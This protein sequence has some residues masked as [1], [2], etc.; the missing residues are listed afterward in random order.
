MSAFNRYLASVDGKNFLVTNLIAEIANSYYELLALDNQLAI[1]RQNIEIQSNALEIVKYQKQSARVTE[2]AVKRFEAQ[3]LNTKSLQFEIQQQI[4]ETENL[5]NFLIGR[6]PQPINRDSES[7]GRFTP[8]MIAEGIPSQL[9][10]NRPDIRQ[11]ELELMAARLDVKSAKANFYPSL[12]ISAGVGYQAFNPAY[13]LKTPE[14]LLY[15]LAGELTAPL[16]NRK[17]IKAIY[18][19][20]NAKQI[21][22][23]FNYEQTVLN[24]YV[25]VANELANINNLASAYDLR[26]RQV[27]VLNESV[28]ISNTLFKSARADYMEVLLTQREA[29]DSRF[30]LIETRMEQLRAVVRVYRSLGGGWK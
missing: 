19:N 18:Q 9:L 5:I 7:F 21:Q 24:A 27:D 25:E 8:N 26:A 28:D 4:I 14:S 3:V 13:V 15:S 1:V 30:D 16:I 10:Q 6:Y 17:G 12:G 22:A 23:V 2:L 29:L 11:A 20:A